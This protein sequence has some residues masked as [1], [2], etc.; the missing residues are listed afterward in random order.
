MPLLP[1]AAA[2]LLLAHG[3]REYSDLAAHTLEIRS[4]AYQLLTGNPA[5]LDRYRAGVGASIE[6][7]DELQTLSADN[8]RQ[9]DEIVALCP[10]PGSPAGSRRPDRR[11]SSAGDVGGALDPVRSGRGRVLMD[12]IRASIDRI[13]AEEQALLTRRSATA[14]VLGLLLLIASLCGIVLVIAIAALSAVRMQRHTAVLEALQEELRAA[15]GN[16][17]GIIAARVADP[18]AANEEIQRFAYIVSHDLRAP[19]ANV[20]GFTS[21][22]DVLREQVTTFSGTVAARVPERADPAVRIALAEDLPEALRFI[23]TSTAKMDR[24]IGAIL[25]LSREGRRMLTPEPADI[26]KVTD[27]VAAS[28]KHQL[29]E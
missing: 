22:L 2:S 16:L 8:P 7:L 10:G 25:R 27:G 21:E 11:A 26:R 24:L 15:N 18:N 14:G 29:A 20:M 6:G 23:R 1:I 5:H 17:E 3:N 13:Q 19:L 12:A 9:Q 4:H 28:L